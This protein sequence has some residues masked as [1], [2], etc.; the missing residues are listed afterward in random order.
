MECGNAAARKA[1][2][3][4]VAELR[5]NLLTAGRVLSPTEDEIQLAWRSYK[6]GLNAG[7]GI[8]DQIS[9]VL[10]KRLKI[11]EA[12]TNDDHFRAARLVV[13]F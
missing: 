8:V 9:F 4:D 12:F 11:T 13:L 6:Y 7:A 2:R 5:T 3:S 10:M 1:Y